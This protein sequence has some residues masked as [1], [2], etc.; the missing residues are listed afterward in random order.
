MAEIIINKERYEC[1]PAVAAHIKQL[2]AEYTRL[3]EAHQKARDAIAKYY[4][5]RCGA[6][7][8]VGADDA[9]AGESE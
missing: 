2:K 8:D 6:E 1:A 4:C 9:R 5:P 3:K 7:M